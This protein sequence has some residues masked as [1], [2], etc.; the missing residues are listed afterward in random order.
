M[1][2]QSSLHAIPLEGIRNKGRVCSFGFTY[3]YHVK[4]N[5]TARGPS[6]RLPP[7][8]LPPAEVSAGW[9]GSDQVPRLPVFAFDGYYCALCVVLRKLQSA[10]P[11]RVAALLMEE[12]GAGVAAHHLAVRRGRPLHPP[13]TAAGGCTDARVAAGWARA[14]AVHRNVYQIT[15]KYGSVGRGPDGLSVE[16]HLLFRVPELQ[17]AGPLV[18]RWLFTVGQ[19]DGGRKI[20]L[21]LHVGVG[22]LEAAEAIPLDEGGRCEPVPGPRGMHDLRGARPWCGAV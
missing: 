22:G 16:F 5:N 3:L 11:V 9:R 15:V 6:G 2:F 10:A 18:R 20:D 17:G 4:L 7:W 13:V 1:S 21:V 14:P 19:G 8:F 12:R